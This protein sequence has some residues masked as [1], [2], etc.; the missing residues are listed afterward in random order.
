MIK[1]LWDAEARDF[2]LVPLERVIE[3]IDHVVQVAGIDHVGLG[4]DFDG[5]G[6][7][8]VELSDASKLP[9]I[10]EKLLAR[11]YSERDIKKILGGN[12]MRVFSDSLV[13][14]AAR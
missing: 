3:H 9:L 10:T 1:S 5:Y 11:G 4:S 8:P 2:P 13:P 7:G 6:T 12:F 14:G